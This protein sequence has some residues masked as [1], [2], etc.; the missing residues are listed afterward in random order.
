[1][2]KEVGENELIETCGRARKASRSR[3]MLS[4]L[5]NRVVNLEE[6][7]GDMKETLKEVLTRMEELME[8]SKEFVLD[9]LRSTSNKLTVRDESLEALVTVM[10]EKIVELKGELI[11]Y[12]V[13]LG[14]RI[15]ASRSKYT[16]KK[17]GRT[18]IRTWE[19]F[20]RELKKQFYQQHA[21]KEAPASLRRLT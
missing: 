16:D 20:Q 5:K 15:L 6:S 3:D 12:K 1:M 10:K 4:S 7:V 13:A 9:T 19:K 21:E 11:I 2:S 18:P 8:C 14:S 17:C